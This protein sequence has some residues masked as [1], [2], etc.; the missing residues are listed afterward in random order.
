MTQTAC[1]TLS[2]EKCAGMTQ[3]QREGLCPKSMR[4]QSQTESPKQ[5]HSKY[6]GR[7]G[8]QDSRISLKG[9]A[10]GG[11]PCKHTRWKCR[12]S[13]VKRRQSKLQFTGAGTVVQWLSSCAPLH[14]PRVCRF[15]SQLQTYTLLKKPR[16]GG[17]PHTEQRKIGRNV[18]S[19]TSFLT[20][21]K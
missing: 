20:K 18:S 16:C 19:G 5:T 17:I 4:E 8:I 3:T 13:R 11:F 7:V 10:D 6:S 12:R 21:R 2:D 15:R 14:W 1:R 9:Q